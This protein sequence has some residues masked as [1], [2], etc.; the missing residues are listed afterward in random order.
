MK[1]L[2]LLFL[3]GISAGCSSNPVTLPDWDLEPAEVTAQEPLAL[4]QLTD[5]LTAEALE[6]LLIISEGN[7]EIAFANA[8]ALNAQAQAYNA[9]IE[10]GK[11]QVQIAEIRQEMLDQERRDH[12]VD[13][14]TYR[15]VI[16]LG[17]IAVAL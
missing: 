12:M 17:L 16:I 5:P 2:A 15:V 1:T 4:P 3:V 13:N 10:A 9:L 11:M 6:S 14:L 7:Y 8:R